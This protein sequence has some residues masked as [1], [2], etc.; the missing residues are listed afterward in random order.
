MVKN[1]FSS[2]G[3]D[4]VGKLSGQSITNALSEQTV[5]II[6]TS[7]WTR[8]VGVR[9]VVANVIVTLNH[10]GHASPVL[11][12]AHMRYF[13][14]NSLFQRNPK[15]DILSDFETSASAKLRY[16]YIINFNS[17]LEI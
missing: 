15:R 10:A 2:F 17:D 6:P 7:W 8:P 9:I 13:H 4:I 3:L 16:L 14:V 1:I 5:N 11:F 12:L